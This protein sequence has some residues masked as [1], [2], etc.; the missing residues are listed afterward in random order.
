MDIL[1]RIFQLQYNLD[2]FCTKLAELPDA[3]KQPVTD[4]SRP[5]PN[6]C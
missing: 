3:P 1:H 5:L 2:R 6:A 4:K